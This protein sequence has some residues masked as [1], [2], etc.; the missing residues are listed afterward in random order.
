MIAEEIMQHITNVGEGY[1]MLRKRVDG[2]N[3]NIRIALSR[4]AK[5]RPAHGLAIRNHYSLESPR[6][7]R[8]RINKLIRHRNWGIQ[9]YCSNS[10]VFLTGL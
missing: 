10:R 2:Y 8:C 7:E 6:D 5:N 1:L 4:P 9:S 3:G